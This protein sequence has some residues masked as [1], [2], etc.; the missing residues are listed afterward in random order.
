MAA[1]E[2]H[3]LD[4]APNNGI[5]YSIDKIEFVIH[6]KTQL[7]PTAFTINANDGTI[8]IGNNDYTDYIG[9][10]FIIYVVAEDYRG[11]NNMTDTQ[12]HVVCIPL[13]C[14]CIVIAFVWTNLLLYLEL[15][16]SYLSLYQCLAYICLMSEF[17][18]AYQMLNIICVHI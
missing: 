18:C 7:A 12:Q 9:G 14:F 3:D 4:L 8:V 15:S 10:Y 6:G 11:G 2:A 17:L 5:R 13:S 16:L 1:A